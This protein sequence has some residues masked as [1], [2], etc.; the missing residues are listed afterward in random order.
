M[1]NRTDSAR[2]DDLAYR[3]AMAG[4]RSISL[5]ILIFLW[6][7]GGA[8][9]AEPTKQNAPKAKDDPNC[10]EQYRRVCTK[11]RTRKCRVVMK[12]DCSMRPANRCRDKLVEKC[13]PQA[14]QVC[15][16][17]GGRNECRYETKRRCQRVIRQ[18]CDRRL[19]RR[20]KRVPRTVC[21]NEPET[22]CEQRR[23]YACSGRKK[24]EAKKPEK[25]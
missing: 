13:V 16:N 17:V 15:R 23:F 9:A 20:C 14:R 5:L 11:V 4:V 19:E 1:V 22:R 24:T 3:L 12:E 10:I 2:R 7:A 25:Q 8:L 21:T 18:V 6:F